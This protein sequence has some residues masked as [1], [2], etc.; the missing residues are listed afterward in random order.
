MRLIRPKIFIPNWLI[1]LIIGLILF[2]IMFLFIDWDKLSLILSNSNLLLIV[3]GLVINFFVMIVKGI[4]W[5]RI[6]EEEKRPP[7]S[8][9]IQLTILSFFLNTIFPARAGDIGRALY[10]AKDRNASKAYSI[11][12]VTLDKAMDF[13]SLLLLMIPLPFFIKLPQFF[14]D[15]FFITGILGIISFTLIIVLS[16]K[17]KKETKENFSTKS[18]VIKALIELIYSFKILNSFFAI[19][20]L[21]LLSL[22]SWILQISI[23]TLSGLA[24]GVSINLL[25]SLLILIAINIAIALP[26]TPANVGTM[27]ASIFMAMTLLKYPK[28]EALSVAIL[29]HAIQILPLFILGPLLTHKVG[30]KFLYCRGSDASTR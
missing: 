1:P 25:T 10:L 5:Q 21:L 30:I 28:E 23:L 11:G 20:Y 4:R 8:Q 6:I 18:R 2:S 14:K 22:L 27:H 19:A 17:V 9:S 7:L 26:A 16:K 24:L 29:F 13:F 15:G 3:A 12:T